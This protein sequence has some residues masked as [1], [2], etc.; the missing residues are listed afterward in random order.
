[1]ATIPLGGHARDVVVSPGG[2][3]V[4]ATTANSVSVIDRAH[5]IVANIPSV[6]TRSA[7]W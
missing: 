6:L 5:H 3:H 7:Q 2:D 1:V 4:Y